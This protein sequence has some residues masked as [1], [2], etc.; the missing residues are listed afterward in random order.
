MTRIIIILHIIGITVSG[1]IHHFDKQS[2][3]TEEEKELAEY[4]HINMDY[5]SPEDFFLIR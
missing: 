1:C 4:D 5:V 2:E 3:L